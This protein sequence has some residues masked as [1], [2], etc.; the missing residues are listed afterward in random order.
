MKK[1]NVVTAAILAMPM[2]TALPAHAYG[3]CSGASD[4]DLGKA[5]DLTD[6]SEV[7]AT[8]A[9]VVKDG[10]YLKV[11]PHGNKCGAADD[12][13]IQFTVQTSDMDY[14]F[15][16][17]TSVLVDING[18]A[19]NTFPVLDADLA[20]YGGNPDGTETYGGIVKKSVADKIRKAGG[21]A[22]ELN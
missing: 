9:A 7:F 6:T 15:N 22:I 14:A 21:F 1:M 8:A 4:K 20:S 2:L 19:P 18:D 3:G 5:V 10:D 17:A 11:G 12:V 13:R 16:N